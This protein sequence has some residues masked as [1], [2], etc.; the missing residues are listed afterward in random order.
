MPNKLS[1]HWGRPMAEAKPNEGATAGGT[2]AKAAPAAR[3]EIPG[4]L[5]YLAASGTLKKILERLTEAAQPPKFN[6][7]FLENVLKLKGGTGKAI[8]PIFK[9][10]GM[11]STN[12]VPIRKT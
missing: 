10:P 8:Q 7:D 9:K 12:G 2:G 3:R 11:P 5:P 6:S 1:Y 4:S